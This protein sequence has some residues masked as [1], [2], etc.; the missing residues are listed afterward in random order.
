[1]TDK[2]LLYPA[3]G[4]ID[5]DAGLTKT[6]ILF[7]LAEELGFDL[8]PSRPAPGTKVRF[9]EFTGD[10]SHS[11]DEVG[12]KKKCTHIGITDRCLKHQQ[13]LGELDGWRVCCEACTKPIQVRTC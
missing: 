7:G 5:E 13:Q 1:M 2:W 4:D 6:E 9:C 12:W 10:E 8:T 11:W 3:E